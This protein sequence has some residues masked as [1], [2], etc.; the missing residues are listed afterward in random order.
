MYAFNFL[1]VSTIFLL[2]LAQ[3]VATQDVKP[4]P[5]GG[6]C[7]TIAGPRPC[8]AGLKCCILGPDNGICERECVEPVPLGGLCVTIAGSKPCV[9]GLK[10]CVLGP[11]NGIGWFVLRVLDIGTL[12]FI[13]GVKQHLKEIW[14]L[15]QIG[16]GGL[17]EAALN[18]LLKHFNAEVEG[19]LSSC[20]ASRPQW[21]TRAEEVVLATL[22]SSESLLNPETQSG[23]N[24]LPR[25]VE[26]SVSSDGETMSHEQALTA[27]KFSSSALK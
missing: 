21:I 16:E 7:E 24:A 14:T 17:E 3:G 4:V 8:A 11:D 2:A 6:L 20:I 12:P 5:K 26:D 9:A 15:W 1:S 10:C 23:K 25:E 19:P 18:A 22:D 13:Q 27:M